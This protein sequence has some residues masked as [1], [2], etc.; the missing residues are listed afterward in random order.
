MNL[1]HREEIK[2]SHGTLEST[3]AMKENGYDAVDFDNGIVQDE[4]GFATLIE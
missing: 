4:I 1:V 2:E 3:L